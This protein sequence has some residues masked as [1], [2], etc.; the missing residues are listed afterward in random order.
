MADVLANLGQSFPLPATL[1]PLFTCSTANGATVS[2]VTV[3][4]QS[5]TQ[6]AH[7]R[8]SLA[9]G[10]ANDSPQQYLFFD[11]TL[12]PNETRSAVIGITMASGDV[13]NCQSDTGTVSFNAS[14]VQ[15]Q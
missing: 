3:C 11:V 10:G 5:S 9:V 14:G 12:Q 1:T 4:N 7:F 13:L 15:V 2:N 6:V 8:L